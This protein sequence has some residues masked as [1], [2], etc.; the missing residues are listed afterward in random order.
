MLS[1]DGWGIFLDRPFAII[2]ILIAIGIVSLRVYQTTRANG[3]KQS[4]EMA[5]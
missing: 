2:F 1:S 3:A 5:E 4:L